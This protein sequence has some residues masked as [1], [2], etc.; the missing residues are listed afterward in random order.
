VQEA[1]Y[2]EAYRERWAEA[3]ASRQARALRARRAAEHLAA[4]LRDRFGARRVLLV[5]SLAHGTFR[6]GSDIDLAVEGL[7]PALLFRAGAVLEREA[8]GFAVDLVPLEDAD[9]GYRVEAEATG[10]VLP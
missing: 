9:L 2:I 10:L 3:E 8:D 4:V 5:G 7:A 6:A 1:E